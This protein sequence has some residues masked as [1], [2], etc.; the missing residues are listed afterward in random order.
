MFSLTDMSLE[1][2]EEYQDT[3]RQEINR[4]NM[5]SMAEKKTENNKVI[6]EVIANIK[7]AFPHLETASQ[8]LYDT[9]IDDECNDNGIDTSGI[10]EAMT[11]L[12]ATVDYLEKKLKE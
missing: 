1:E 4:R 10:D 11:A 6:S 5:M 9:F 2:L 3:I 8:M 7:T 12:L